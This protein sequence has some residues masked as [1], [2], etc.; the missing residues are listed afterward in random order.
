M[1][2]SINRRERPSWV[3]CPRLCVGMVTACPRKAV[4]MAPL[5]V[6]LLFLVASPCCAG[7]LDARIDKLVADAGVTAETP[8]VGVM[9]VEK[10]KV[11]FRKGYGL[12]RLKDKTAFSPQTTCEI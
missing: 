3:P 4:G 6:S 1:S 8:G 2:L 9:V 12:A 5:I 10:G 7:E 11:V